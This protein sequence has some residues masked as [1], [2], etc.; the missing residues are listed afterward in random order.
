MTANDPKQ[1]EC[2]GLTWVDTLGGPHILVPQSALPY[3]HGAPMDSSEDEGDYGRACSVP[4][5]IGL[6]RVGPAEAL[7]KAEP[8][9]TTFLAERKAL[10]SWVGAYSEQELVDVATEVMD[11]ESVP[12]GE[13]LTYTVDE[14]LVLFDSVYGHDDVAPENRLVID[15][16]PGRYTVRA[17]YVEHPRAY[18]ILVQFT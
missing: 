10:I 13:E 6:I 5:Y 7:V 16:A 17:A 3:W 2:S 9:P 14:P 4:G 8:S 15:L 1:A 11:A 18:L 12:E